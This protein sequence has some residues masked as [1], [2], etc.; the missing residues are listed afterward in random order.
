MA[1]FDQF[2]AALETSLKALVAS[3]LGD[4][5][6]AATKD[7]AAFVAKCKTDLEK[8]TTQLAK[9]ELSEADFA[10]QLR[11]ETDLGAMVALKRAGLTAARLQKFHDDHIERIV[12]AAATVFLK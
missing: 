11:S 12:H 1:T 9:G 6:D 8:W 7:G 5:K 2:T 4:V 3:T 10:F